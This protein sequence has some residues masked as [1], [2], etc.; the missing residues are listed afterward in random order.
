MKYEERQIFYKIGRID[1][2]KEISIGGGNDEQT[3]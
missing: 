2:Y 3:I 1:I